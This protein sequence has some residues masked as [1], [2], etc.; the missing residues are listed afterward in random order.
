WTVFQSL[1]A[2]AGWSCATPAPGASGAITCTIPSLAVGASAPFTLTVAPIDCSTPDAS[3]IVASASVT[4]T[5]ADPNP[6][7]NNASSASVQ[8][9]NAPPLITVSGALDTTIECATAFTDPGATAEDACDGPV[10][11]SASSTVDVSTVGTYAVTY[12][13]TDRA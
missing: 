11:V 4:S 9:S 3:F 2:P 1:A 7:A 10:A 13:A 5:T 6:A 12:N 8:V